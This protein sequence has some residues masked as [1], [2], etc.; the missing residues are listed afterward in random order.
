MYVHLISNSKLT[1][2]RSLI[3]LL[4][5]VKLT[6]SEQVSKLKAFKIKIFCP[7]HKILVRWNSVNLP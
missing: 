4:V 5:T 7:P 2:T 3:G 6:P 1:P